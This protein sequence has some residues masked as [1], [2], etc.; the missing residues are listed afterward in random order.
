MVNTFITMVNRIATELRRSNM[1]AEIKNA[2]NDAISREANQRFYFNEVRGEFDAG[3]SFSTVSG[4]EYYDDMGFVEVDAMYYYIGQTRYNVLPWNK[5]QADRVARGG[6]VVTSQ[7]VLFSRAAEKFRIWPKP[8]VV[9]TLYVDGFGKLLPTPLVNDADTNTWMTD[10]ELL[11]RAS[12]KAIL[13]KDVIRDYG[14]ATAVEA[15]ASDYR[16]SLLGQTSLVQST[17]TMK[18][19]QW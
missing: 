6:P 1:T 14:E 4:T 3:F 9:L 7:P 5:L 8:N 18:P 2:I 11:I 12:A 10:G 17:E 15:I 16:D 13:L 19:T